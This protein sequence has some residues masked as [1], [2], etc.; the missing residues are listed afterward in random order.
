M[1]GLIHCVGMLGLLM[2]AVPITA[3]LE[4]LPNDV[5]RLFSEY[6]HRPISNPPKL[7]VSQYQFSPL[8]TK[9][10]GESVNLFGNLQADTLYFVD[11]PLVYPSPLPMS[12]VRSN[13]NGANPQQ[14]PFL[15]YQLSKH[16]DMELRMY[17]SFALEI[18]RKTFPRGTEGGKG[19]VEAN[20][21]NYN[22]LYLNTAFFNNKMLPSGVYFYV[23][24]KDGEVVAK[25]KFAVVP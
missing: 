20:E 6:I 22:K 10:P 11:P 9:P 18:F 15:G 24:I 2:L 19:G 3:E 23:F 5:I 25:G 13:S 1:R 21:S 8:Q 4:L 12:L 7:F 14:D 17:D 16:M